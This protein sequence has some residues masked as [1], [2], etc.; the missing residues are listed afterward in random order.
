MNAPPSRSTSRGSGSARST[1]RD[2]KLGP[3]A[4]NTNG[5]DPR[6]DERPTTNPAI[7]RFP[8]IPEN[9]RHDIMV[10][11]PG[12]DASTTRSSASS[13]FT[14]PAELLKTHRYKPEEAVEAPRMTSTA[15]E[16]PTKGSPFRSHLYFTYPPAWS[17]AGCSAAPGRALSLPLDWDES[18][19]ASTHNTAVE[20]SSIVC[21]LGPC[22]TT[23]SV[24]P[25][26][27]LTP[28]AD[29]ASSTAQATRE[30]SNNFREAIAVFIISIGDRGWFERGA[31]DRIWIGMSSLETRMPS[32]AKPKN[33]TAKSA[34]RR[35]FPQ[36]S[37]LAGILNE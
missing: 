4:R 35:P 28:S 24:A 34:G 17:A 22:L 7:N 20:P 5:M 27:H 8:P 15:S 16:A 6:M 30:E 12:H 25:L 33:S 21:E 29:V 2:N 36:K 31:P 23:G 14:E 11:C 32:L 3:E 1:P 26:A 9:E 37:A 18:S 19:S 13:V 10:K